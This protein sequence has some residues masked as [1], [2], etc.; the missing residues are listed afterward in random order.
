MDNLN[1]IYRVQGSEKNNPFL[2]PACP[3]K[4]V[5]VSGD[6]KIKLNPDTQHFIYF[7]KT[8][9]HHSY[10]MYSKVLK[11]ISKEIDILRKS[12]NGSKLDIPNDFR[13]FR[14]YSHLNS[15]D[16]KKVKELLTNYTEPQEVELI[17]MQYM[18]AFSELFE[19]CATKN[20]QKNFGKNY[21]EVSDVSTFGGAY[22]INDI[23]LELLK[24][25]TVL[26]KTAQVPVTDILEELLKYKN[27]V[28]V[29]DQRLKSVLNC[30]Q[31][32]FEILDHL[33]Y[34]ELSNPDFIDKNT[35][36]KITYLLELI[37]EYRLYSPKL[38]LTRKFF[39][40]Q[41]KKFKDEYH[42][43]LEAVK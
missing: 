37:E 31:A 4:R 6:G 22:G 9:N 16:I 24:Q 26:T 36:N 1:E 12:S 42:E 20:H 28:K 33:Q 23:W 21:P 7:S 41:R 30:N 17:T 2:N 40:S 3:I 18:P 8:R 43:I 39:V 13:A 38:P 35:I 19:Y 32:L 10:Y 27:T 15:D 5:L 34:K 29:T 14:Y 25:C 11:I